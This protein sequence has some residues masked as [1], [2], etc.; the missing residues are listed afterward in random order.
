MSENTRIKL[1]INE[2]IKSV[3]YNCKR[4]RQK[5]NEDGRLPVC[6]AVN[7]GSTNLKT[8]IFIFAAVRS[9]I[10]VPIITTV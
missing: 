9:I 1:H 8:A 5:N 6:S 10:T 3:I 2:R 7:S 4:I